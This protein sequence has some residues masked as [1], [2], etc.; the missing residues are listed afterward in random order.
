MLEVN[1]GNS[2]QL[3]IFISK[4]ALNLD[5]ISL[6]FNRNSYEKEIVWLVTSY[7]YEIWKKFSRKSEQNVKKEQ[8]FGFLKYKYR[9]NQL[10]ARLKLQEI[11]EFDQVTVD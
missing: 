7:V 8:M 10:G 1:Q 3:S 2:A 4:F 11:R 9:K 6:N 5:L